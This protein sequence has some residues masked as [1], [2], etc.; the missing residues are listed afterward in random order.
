MEQRT[1]ASAPWAVLIP[2]AHHS[3]TAV[4]PWQDPLIDPGLRN[5]TVGKDLVTGNGKSTGQ[6]EESM[7]RRYY[8]VVP[9][10]AVQRHIQE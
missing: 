1:W 3:I 10:H 6:K 5:L 8:L 7:E 9:R 4:G 2:A